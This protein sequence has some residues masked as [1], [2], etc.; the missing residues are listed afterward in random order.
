MILDMGSINL[1]Y[2]NHRRNS[3][4][5]KDH[6]SVNVADEQP[7]QRKRSWVRC[8]SD[9]H[10]SETASGI[11]QTPTRSWKQWLN[12]CNFPLSP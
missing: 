7:T 10:S 1:C 9:S 2:I 5:P 12:A 6:T 3:S 8:L 4:N 11:H